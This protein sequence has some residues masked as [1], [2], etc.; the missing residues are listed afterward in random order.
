[1]QTLQHQGELI[2]TAKLA[3]GSNI[4]ILSGLQSHAHD[5]IVGHSP[6]WESKAKACVS[7]LQRNLK[8]T[9]DIL[10]RTKEASNLVSVLT[11]YLS[12]LFTYSCSKMTAL[13][14]FKHSQ[15]LSLNSASTNRLAEASREEGRLI[16]ML[17]KSSKK[18]SGTMR[19]ITVIT[20]LY[21]PGT[22]V[23]VSSEYT[24]PKSLN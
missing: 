14:N 18:D 22:F 1:M 16:L 10:D 17:T 15:A 12:K 24:L 13:F 6:L 4:E 8:W 11:F 23:A 21:L 2:R 20:M 7:L 5:D 9:D 19:L 3:I